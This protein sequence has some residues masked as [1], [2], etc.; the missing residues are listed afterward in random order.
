MDAHFD[1]RRL[2][3][4]SLRDEA[5]LAAISGALP[6]VWHWHD[7]QAASRSLAMAVF[8][9]I[10]AT[11]RTWCIA[12][13]ASEKLFVELNHVIDRGHR[14][15]AERHPSLAA[16]VGNCEI[17]ECDHVHAYDGAELRLPGNSVATT[18]AMTTPFGK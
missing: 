11:A 16:D 18:P 3:T 12:G 10:T 5:K 15:S 6:N 8:V 13:C 2:P 4:V 14:R 1:P 17:T 9:L 7:R